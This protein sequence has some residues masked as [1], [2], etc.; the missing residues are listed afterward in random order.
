[1]NSQPIKLKVQDV[2]I[3]ARSKRELY[4]MLQLE[5][6]VYL[7]PLSQ[8]NHDYVSGILSG[9]RKVRVD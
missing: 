2:S 5:G 8:A 1:M 4:R 3:H 7:P 9:K 6:D